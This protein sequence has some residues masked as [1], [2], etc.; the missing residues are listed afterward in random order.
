MYV[1]R[2]DPSVL[3][4]GLSS[5]RHS[6]KSSIY[7]KWGVGGGGGVRQ[8]EEGGGGEGGEGVQDQKAQDPPHFYDTFFSRQ[9]FSPV[10]L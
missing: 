4:F 7:L 10:N 3:T 1:R 8:T 9:S 5:H 6:Y 2:V